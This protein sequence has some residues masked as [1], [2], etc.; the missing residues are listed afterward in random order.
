MNSSSSFC[1]CLWD[2]DT[3]SNDLAG[4]IGGGYSASQIA[5]GLITDPLTENAPAIGNASF[6]LDFVA[7]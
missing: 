7:H 2:V 3:T 5:A 4:C 1:I 6:T